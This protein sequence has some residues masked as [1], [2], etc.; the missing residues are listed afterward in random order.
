MFFLGRNSSDLSKNILTEVGR[1]M[2]GVVL[3]ILQ[4]IS[5]SIVAF[6]LVLLL[7]ADDTFLAGTILLALG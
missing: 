7:V 6:L 4:V 5:K 3:P 1:A 2:S